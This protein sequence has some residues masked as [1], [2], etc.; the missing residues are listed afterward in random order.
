MAT[1]AGRR[2]FDVDRTEQMLGWRP[3]AEFADLD[4]ERQAQT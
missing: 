1:A 2:W 3:A 4:P